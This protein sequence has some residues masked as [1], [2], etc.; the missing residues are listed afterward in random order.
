MVV[1][2]LHFEV[3]VVAGGA[4]DGAAGGSPGFGASAASPFGGTSSERGQQGSKL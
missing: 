3:Y 4:F 2:R 1:I